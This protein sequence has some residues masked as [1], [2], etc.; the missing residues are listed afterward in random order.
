MVDP[1]LRSEGPAERTVAI[2]DPL[3]IEAVQR[4]VND[5]ENGRPA[6]RESLIDRFSSIAEPLAACLDGLDIL[7]RVVPQLKDELKSPVDIES[8]EPIHPSATLG[9]FRILREIGRGGMGVVYAAE[10]LSLGRQVALKVLPFAAMMDKQQL[11]RFK[12]EAR[13]AATLDHPHVVSVYSVGDERGV[14]YY[15]MQLV[16]GITLEAFIRQ[17]RREVETNASDHAG[18][19]RNA[20]RPNARAELSTDAIPHSPTNPTQDTNRILAATASTAVPADQRQYCL[21]VARIGLQAAEALAHAHE[22]GILHRDIKPA[23]LLVDNEG[24]LYVTDF[25]LAR[26]QSDTDLSVTGDLVGTLRYMSPEQAGGRNSLLDARSDIY[27][28][29]VSLYEMLTLTPAVKG[30]DRASLVKNVVD[31]E[32]AAPRKLVRSIPTDLDTIVQKSI[33]KD[34][35]DRYVSMNDLAEDLRR[36]LDFQPVLARKPRMS[37]RLSRWIRRHATFVA[38]IVVSL[39]LIAA[40]SLVAWRLADAERRHAKRNLEAALDVTASVVGPMMYSLQHGL[41]PQFAN[42]QIEKMIEMLE[43]LP[44]ASNDRRFVRELAHLNTLLA[45]NQ[46]RLGIDSTEHAER[47]VELAKQYFDSSPNDP[48]AAVLLAYANRAIGVAAFARGQWEEAVAAAETDLKLLPD[49]SLKPS[50]HIWARSSYSYYLRKACRIEDAL[51][52]SRESLKLVRQFNSVGISYAAR[53][54]HI[55]T[56]LEVPDWEKADAVA[57]EA[58]QLVDT[59]LAGKLASRPMHDAWKARVHLAA[60]QVRN[61][62]YNPDDAIMQVEECLEILN[63]NESVS[64]DSVFSVRDFAESHLQLCDAHTLNGNLVQAKHH[65]H[66]SIRHWQDVKHALG[67]NE[68]ARVQ[69]RLAHILVQTG[70]TAKAQLELQSALDRM[71]LN[72]Q[73]MPNEL[74]HVRRLLMLL[75]L[76]PISTIGD[77]ALAVQLADQVFLADSQILARY[78]ALAYSRAGQHNKAKQCT[79]KITTRPPG[80]DEIDALIATLVYANAGDMAVAEEHF[81]HAKDAMHRKSPVHFLDSGPLV[82]ELLRQQVVEIFSHKNADET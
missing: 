29:G 70:Q 2:D 65:A 38:V 57:I 68:V 51:L 4:Y 46:A 54:R 26:I 20:D 10:Q 47:A 61:G 52:Q 19:F 48:R 34:P 31:S 44:D 36:F 3:V 14:H 6:D 8:F 60:A 28:L 27:S 17:R 67:L 45:R 69:F 42:A 9:D 24:T 74:F 56:L 5:L 59:L 49:V 82:V 58:L 66:D 25:G 64:P 32:P 33:A 1:E 75:T 43:Q 16:D 63:L 72:V 39:M 7:H 15:A 18:D 50:A 12:N 76:S 41:D 77:D 23:N 37:Y 13:A 73:K 22:Q 30:Q 55:L 79:R 35:E 11:K 71:R 81:T 40:F 21:N 62:Q 78:M 80:G 53:A